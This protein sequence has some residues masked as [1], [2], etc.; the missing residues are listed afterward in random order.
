MSHMSGKT[1]LVALGGDKNQVLLE[2]ILAAATVWAKALSVGKGYG[3]DYAKESTGDDTLVAQV[4]G[5]HELILIVTVTEEFDTGNTSQTEFEIGYDNS[6][7]SDSIMASS[8]LTDAPVGFQHIVTKTIDNKAVVVNR[9]QAEG[10]GTGA[11]HVMAF[12]K[13]DA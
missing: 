2:D 10:T 13:P 12:V 11:I 3:K 4:S 6:G 9:T 8:V 7:N 1:A 5:E